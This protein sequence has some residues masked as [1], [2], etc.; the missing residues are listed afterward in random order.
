[1][2]VLSSLFIY[3]YPYILNQVCKVLFWHTFLSTQHWFVDHSV[4]S[5]VTIYTTH[6]CH[7]FSHCKYMIH[8]ALVSFNLK[9]NHFSHI[10]MK[11]FNVFT[12]IIIIITQ[13]SLERSH[14]FCRAVELDVR[15]GVIYMYDVC[16][17]TCAY[18]IY[19][20]LWPG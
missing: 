15:E 7:L 11:I 5:L 9:F 12:N 3:L 13:E 17:G 19:I 1:M 20:P 8:A 10:Y 18:I 14:Y 2:Y 16:M 4:C 6:F